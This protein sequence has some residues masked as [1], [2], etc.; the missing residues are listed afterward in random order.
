MAN[1]LYNGNNQRSNGLTQSGSG[2]VTLNVGGASFSKVKPHTQ[3]F[4]NTQD[5]DNTD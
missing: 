2:A 4:E 1:S 3:V 5:V